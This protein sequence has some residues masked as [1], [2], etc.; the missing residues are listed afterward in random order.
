MDE[1]N[2]ST[3]AP[4]KNTVEAKMSTAAPIATVEPNTTT[5]TDDR[6][7]PTT[8]PQAINKITTQ[9]NS[10]LVLRTEV[11]I[12]AEGIG[13]QQGTLHAPWVENENECSL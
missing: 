3:T 2:E 12:Q 13:A 8:T 5:P 6:N 4:R 9:A 10:S 11:D 1:T 7:H